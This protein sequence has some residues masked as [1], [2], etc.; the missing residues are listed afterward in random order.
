MEG[1]D[2]GCGA[3]GG[4]NSANVLEKTGVIILTSAAIS[5]EKRDRKYLLYSSSILIH[6]M[7]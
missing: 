3:G 2:I 6:V 7:A 1:Y 4:Q 5:N